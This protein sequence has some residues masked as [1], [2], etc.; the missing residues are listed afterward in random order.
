MRKGNKKRPI[1][2]PNNPNSKFT[3]KRCDVDVLNDKALILQ[4]RT[5]GYSIR[6]IAQD[7]RLNHLSH[8]IIARDL[9][10]IREDLKDDI[11]EE[12]DVLKAEAVAK[13]NYV[14][15]EMSQAWEASKVLFDFDLDGL[16]D[17]LKSKIESVKKALSKIGNH[18]YAE[19]YLKAVAEQNRIVGLYSAEKKDIRLT[20]STATLTD[21]ELEQEIATLED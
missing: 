15:R 21:A 7:P 16:D 17:R 20:N 9:K 6:Q 5:Q 13:C 19:T 12:F 8:T 10:E 1:P 4:L 2:N 11:K 3:R 14:T 18:K